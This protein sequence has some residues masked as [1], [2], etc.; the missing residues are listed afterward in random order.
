[1]CAQAKDQWE[2]VGSLDEM[3]LM[4]LDYGLHTYVGV[5]TKIFN[6]DFFLN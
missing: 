5:T 3:G 6:N 1:M 2:L 4:V